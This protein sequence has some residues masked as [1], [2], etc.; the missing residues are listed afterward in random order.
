MACSAM[1]YVQ[2]QRERG[3]MWVMVPCNDVCHINGARPTVCVFVSVWTVVC[4][5]VSTTACTNC[6]RDG[7]GNR[8]CGSCAMIYATV[9]VPLRVALSAKYAQS[10]MQ[11]C[12]HNGMCNGISN[13]VY[14]NMCT[15]M[16]MDMRAHA[17]QVYENV[18]LLHACMLAHMSMPMSIH[19]SA[20]MFI[21]TAIHMAG[22]CTDMCIGMCILRELL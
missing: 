16:C 13:G 21:H 6:M 3:N 22:M 12:V 10:C 7:M 11:Q 18:H 15:D 14:I 17:F 2:P 8:G 9:C 1:G 19:M 4:A 5:M 20:H